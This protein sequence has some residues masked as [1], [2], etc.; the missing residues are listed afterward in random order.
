MVELWLVM[1][2]QV[3]NTLYW[4]KEFF[5]SASFSVEELN[6]IGETEFESRR[7]LNV[8]LKKIVDQSKLRNCLTEPGLF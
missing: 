3:N 5:Y 1:E 8:R 2:P 4:A 7:F 6:E